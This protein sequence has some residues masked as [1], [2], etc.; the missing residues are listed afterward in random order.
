MA[1]SVLCQSR[2]MVGQFKKICDNEK[3]LTWLQNILAFLTINHL[4]AELRIEQ[5]ILLHVIPVCIIVPHDILKKIRKHVH[6]LHL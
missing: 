3:S 1:A 2:N 4:Q 5:G 6:V